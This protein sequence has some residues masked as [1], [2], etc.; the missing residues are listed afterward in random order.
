[1]LG[2]SLTVLARATASPA[3]HRS[4]LRPRSP[5]TWGPINNLTAYRSLV[6]AL[7]Y[8]TFTRHAYAVQQVCLH[9]HYP[10]VP[11]HGREAHPSVP[12]GHPHLGLLLRRASTSDLVV[13]T[14]VD[15]A[16]CPATHRSTSG[17]A[18]FLGD[19]LVPWSSKRQNVVSRSRTVS[20]VPRCGQ[21]RGRG[22]L[23]SSAACG[24]AQPPVA[25]HSSTATTSIP[26]TSPPTPFSTSAPSIC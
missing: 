2:T 24:A 12:P 10:R 9:M 25:G 26:S 4:T 3:P 8:L 1:M 20:G 13:Y 23:A 7:Q 21:Q 14:D 16:G 18:V 15:W 19:N 6:G 5:P 17:Y 22:V 11:S